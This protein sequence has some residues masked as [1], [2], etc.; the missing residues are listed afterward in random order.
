MRLKLAL[1]TG[2]LQTDEKQILEAKIAQLSA[3]VE[4]KKKSAGMLSS[5]LKEAEVGHI[6]AATRCFPIDQSLT[7]TFVPLC[8]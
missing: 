2:D 5:I 8:R 4:E 1:L 6:A 3:D 7:W